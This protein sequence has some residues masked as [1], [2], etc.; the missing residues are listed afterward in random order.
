MATEEEEGKKVCVC[1]ESRVKTGG[2]GGDGGN[3][4]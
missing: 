3:G 1:V 2:R 4:G